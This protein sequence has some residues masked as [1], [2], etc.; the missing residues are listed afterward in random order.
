MG[1]LLGTVLGTIRTCAGDSGIEFEA[2][3]TV[4]LLRSALRDESIGERTRI[5]IMM[6]SWL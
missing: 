3:D 4:K 5:D 6:E 1:L 2:Q